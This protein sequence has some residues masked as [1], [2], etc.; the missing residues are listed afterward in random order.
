MRR[1]EAFCKKWDMLP[2][3]ELVLCA[4]SG[5]RDSMALLHLLTS[6]AEAGGFAVAAAHYNHHLRPT[7]DRDEAFVRDWCCAHGV[8]LTC[9]SGD[10]L[11]RAKETGQ[12][13]EEAARS[14]RYAFLEETALA[15]GASRIAT[16]HHLQDNAETVL[17]NL[18][19]GTGLRGLTGIPP[20]RGRIVRP[21]LETDRGEIECYIVENDIPFVE[22]ETNAETIYT[23]NRLRLELMPQ[24]EA[25]LPGCTG[26][27]AATASLL[28]EDEESLRRR[29]EALLPPA[30]GDNEISIP[31][32]LLQKQDEAIARRLVRL[33]AQRLGVSLSREQTL[34]VL[35][36]GS[37]G[38]MDLP[39]GLAACRQ[40]HR[41]TLAR[42]KQP[43]QPMELHVGRQRW[44]DFLVELAEGGCAGENTISLAAERLVGELTIGLWD[45]TGRMAVENGSRSIK[46]LFADRGIPVE[47]RDCHPAL[48]CQGEV[49]A[50][51]GV[52][53]D[54]G[55]WPRE[56]ERTLTISLQK[57]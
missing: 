37:G 19:R 48:Y 26:R 13:V 21:L 45:G 17:L 56:G 23:R 34:A 53:T 44:G 39:A 15:L 38:H 3:G 22:D 24:L 47:R 20:V 43:P 54:A 50:V 51:F 42:K 11:A 18:L 9:G 31:V 52:A 14:L 57:V 55:F 35:S 7:A 32:P 25:F 8:A 33:M 41:L 30:E 29:A 49:I 36:L 2:P 1:V 40:P 4:V 16:A 27:I 6:M 12:S 10:V 28:W 5:G 46:R